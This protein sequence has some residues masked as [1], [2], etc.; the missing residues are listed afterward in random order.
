MGPSPTWHEHA[1]LAHTHLQPAQQPREAARV[2]ATEAVRGRI[3]QAQQAGSSALLQHCRVGQG[4]VARQAVL[5][6][7]AVRVEDAAQGACEGRTSYGALEGGL[8]LLTATADLSPSS[9]SASSAT[10]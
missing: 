2:D 5:D 3:Q 9:S 1:S 6:E 4:R 10:M 7:G 8:T